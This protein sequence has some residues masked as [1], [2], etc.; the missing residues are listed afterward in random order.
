MLRNLFSAVLLR[1]TKI[2]GVTFT[3]VTVSALF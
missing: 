2:V 1:L 3:I